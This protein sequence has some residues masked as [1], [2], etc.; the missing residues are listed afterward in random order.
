[1][2]ASVGNV[3]QQPMATTQSGNIT[4]EGLTSLSSQSAA[5]NG[6]TIAKTTMGLEIK[7]VSRTVIKR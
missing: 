1:M 5:T 3:M 4:C 6:D 7:F 2:A